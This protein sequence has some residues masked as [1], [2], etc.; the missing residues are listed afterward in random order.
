MEM[1]D[2][3]GLFFGTESTRQGILA[4]AALGSAGSDDDL[5]S[6]LVAALETE[7]RPDGTVGGAVVPTIWRVHEL[8]DLGRGGQEP[9]VGRAVS[10]VLG[11]QGKPG[12]FGEG[13]DKPRHAQRICAHYVR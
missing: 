13:C 9:A 2:R 3:L 6:R 1:I 7:I 12:A 10:W 8:L 11:L 4:R 5:V